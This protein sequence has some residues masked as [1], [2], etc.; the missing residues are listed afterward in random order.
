M[1]GAPACALAFAFVLASIAAC[2]RGAV[3][4]AGPPATA[5]GGSTQNSTVVPQPAEAQASGRSGPAD[6]STAIGGVVT[7]QGGNNAATG[8][9]PAPTAGDGAASAASR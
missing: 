1:G 2:D 6:A 3:P 4:S 9:K 5:T 7:H 8:S